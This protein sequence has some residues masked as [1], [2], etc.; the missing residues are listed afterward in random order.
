M[1]HLMAA[2][3]NSNYYELNLVHPQTVN[4]WH[5][6]VYGDGYADELSSIDKDGYVPVPQGPG[7]G[8]SYDWKAIDANRLEQK[9]F[10]L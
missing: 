6:P 2:L 4:A 7:L 8:V 10:T 9:V 3:R 1:R 5:L